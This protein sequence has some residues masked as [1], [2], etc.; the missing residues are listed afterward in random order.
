M[1]VTGE[2]FERVRLFFE[3]LHDEEIAD[4]YDAPILIVGDEGDGKSTFTVGCVWNWKQIRGE[5]PTVQNVLNTIVWDS[6]EEFKQAL[7]NYPQRAAV[8]VMD[9]ARVMMN[10]QSMNPE[11]I[12]AQQDMLDS[13]T[14]EYVAF[15]C[16]QDWG[17]VPDFLRRRRAK[18][19]F[20]IPKR[21]EVQGYNRES[22]DEV[23]A[24]D[25]EE[26]PEPDLR[27]RFPSLE[28]TDLWA[29]F[30]R[31]DRERKRSRMHANDDGDEE[32][33]GMTPQE[34]VADIKESGVGEYVTQNPANKVLSISKD[35]ILYDYDHLSHNEADIVK[36]AL[37]REVDVEAAYENVEEEVGP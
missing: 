17:D 25:G 30:K 11:Q 23:Y 34:A 6:T 15:L 31:R 10:K 20:R 36:S 29:E 9:A 37:A 21:G 18:Y 12:E 24:E 16:Y 3:L 26:W 13:R 22:L 35:L 7:A 19:C 28:G 4:E 5:T 33:S 27:D 2:P 1:I 32:D 14:M 8:P